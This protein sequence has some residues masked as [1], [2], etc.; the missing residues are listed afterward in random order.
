V[1]RARGRSDDGERRRKGVDQEVEEL[2]QARYDEATKRRRDEETKKRT[3]ECE[4]GKEVWRT[5]GPSGPAPAHAT[6]AQ[7]VTTQTQTEVCRLKV[8]NYARRSGYYYFYD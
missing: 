5:S 7:P 4:A 1:C 2:E 6:H 8:S 3:T